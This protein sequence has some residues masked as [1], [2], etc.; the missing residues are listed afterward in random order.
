MNDFE[1]KY[2]EA[3][4]LWS[5]E[6]LTDVGNQTRIRETANLIPKDVATL[7]DIGCGNGILENYLIGNRPELRIIGIDRSE[8][9][10]KYVKTEKK[11]GD[12]LD[13]PL[14]DKGYDCVSCLE[15]LEHI[16]VT[17]YD[18]ALSELARVSSNYL[19]ISVPYNEDLLA[20]STQCPGCKAIFNYDLHFRS[21]SDEV[22][23]KLF[24]P[25]GFELVKM[26]TLIKSKVLVGLDSLK[27]LMGIKPLH[28]RVF[29][30]PICPICGLENASFAPAQPVSS[31]KEPQNSQ[32]GAGSTNK[33]KGFLGTIKDIV[34][35]IWPKKEFPGYW[36][37][38]LYKRVQQ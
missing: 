12:I 18:K 17:V 5:G 19:I 37:L 6:M 29:Y 36:V 21:Y 11:L 34:K 3:D 22:L 27:S 16:P 13:I 20:N 35:N 30:S 25:Y 32:T 31:V 7:A 4:S 38:A 9:A 2:Y 15:V 24:I 28:K 26:Q 23:K 1:K 33:G 10:L 14:D 8:A